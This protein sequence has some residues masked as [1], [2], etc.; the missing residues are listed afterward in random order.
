MLEPGARL[1]PYEIL[2]VIGK[3]GMG[4][5]YRA[6]DSRL[7]RDVAIKILSEELSNDQAAI[8]RF[9]REAKAVAA[10]SHPNIVSIF[11]FG[12]NDGITFAVTELLEG[13]TLRALLQRTRLTWRRACEIAIDVVDA[14]SAAHGRGIIHRD[15]KPENIFIGRDGRVKVLD[16]GLARTSAPFAWRGDDADTL[17]QETS[18]GELVGTPGYMSPE[19]IKGENAEAPSDLFSFGCVLYEMLDGE[20]AFAR[21]TPIEGLAAILGERPK[22]LANVP[23]ELDQL[24]MHCLAKDPSA[25]YQSAHDVALTLRSLLDSTPPPRTINGRIPATGELRPA[26]F[27]T[28]QTLYARSGDVNIAYQ[29]VGSG[30][31]DLVFVMGWITHLE[32]FWQEPSFARFL[33]RLASFSR[34]ILIDKRG[35]GLSD[36][37]PLHQLPTLEQRMDDVRAVMEAVGSPRAALC[38]ISEGGPM[39][40]LFAATYPE[41][42]SALVMIGT[43]AKRIRSDDYP[44]GPTA[45]Q[46]E[47]FFELMQR[48]WGGPV[49]LNE[50]APSKANDPA[51]REWWAKYLR[52]GASP[53][54][55]VALTRMNAEIDVRHVL[56]TIRVPSLIIHRSGDLCLKVEE[57]RY[58]ASR[59]PKAKYVELPGNDHLPFVGDQ[60]AIVDEVEEFLTGV[61]QHSAPDRVLATILHVQCRASSQL[62]SASIDRELAWFRGRLIELDANTLQAAFDGPARAVRCA[63]A[64][65]KLIDGAAAG[66]HTGECDLVGDSFGGP[67]LETGAAIA[68][69]ANAGE[70]LVSRTVRDLVAGSGIAFEEDGELDE[71]RL[72]RVC[73]DGHTMP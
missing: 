19:Q 21:N 69:R 56:P 30:P 29:V 22:T 11:D 35:T 28:P 26:T 71:W 70:V 13:E 36:R 64:I 20:R 38:G 48:E 3:G 33:R 54:A 63:S 34:L 61:R 27:E 40:S 42:T 55:A 2:S 15:L 52:M 4:R 9:E 53:G 16:F 68:S 31:L 32:Y 1:G 12:A 6:R 44:W 37:V 62:A 5:V 7:D 39:C 24:V 41:R 51:F 10:L 57:G 72:Y 46:R 14:L 18:P 25:R 73:D 8:V 65:C 58:V 45:E 17:R 66:V 60:D 43:Y 50:R 23:A 49:G 47:A 59:I 67:P